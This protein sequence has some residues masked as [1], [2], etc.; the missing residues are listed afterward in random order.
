VLGRSSA[1][2]ASTRDTDTLIEV[3][4][5]L[6]RFLGW[7]AR[8]TGGSGQWVGPPPSPPA[9]RQKQRPGRGE[10]TCV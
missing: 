4:R 10:N 9:T 1:A 5:V 7:R 2:A 6:R 8:Q 3:L